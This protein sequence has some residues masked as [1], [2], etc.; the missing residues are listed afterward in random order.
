MQKGDVKQTLSDTKVL[1]N[2][3]NYKTKINY[4]KGLSK[5]IDWFRKFYKI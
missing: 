2:L 1:Y 3:T 5:F 4:D